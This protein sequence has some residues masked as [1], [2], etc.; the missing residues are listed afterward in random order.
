MRVRHGGQDT[1][2][3][4]LLH[5]LGATGDVWDGLTGLLGRTAPELRTLHVHS[6]W[7]RV[8]AADAWGAVLPQLTPRALHWRATGSGPWPL[9]CPAPDAVPVPDVAAEVIAGQGTVGLELLAARPDL[10][11]VPVGGGGLAAGV[12][13]APS[14]QVGARTR[15]PCSASERM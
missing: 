12:A 11:L 15:S 10:V 14:G 7:H 2:S 5:G 3:V 4:L 1:P 9:W 13:C 8:L 6:G